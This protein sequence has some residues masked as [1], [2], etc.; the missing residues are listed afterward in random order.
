MAAEVKADI[1]SLGKEIE[2]LRKH[3]GDLAGDAKLSADVRAATSSISKK[4][5][6]LSTV[7]T[8]KASLGLP[9]S[10]SGSPAKTWPPRGGLAQVANSLALLENAKLQVPELNKA[11]NLAIKPA[12]EQAL[13]KALA[14]KAAYPDGQ[15]VVG[16][17]EVSSSFGIRGNPFGGA[18]YEVH[19]GIDFIGEQGDIIAATGN[20]VVTQAGFNGG[21]GISVTI[22]HGYGYE[23]LYAHMSEKRVSSGDEV[24]RGQIIGYIGSTGRSSGP[25]LHYGIYKDNVA[26]DPAE[27]MASPERQMA[28]GPR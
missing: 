17:A 11:V 14:V 24:K 9:I 23:T 7:T 28:V 12:L 8:R 4:R 20:G 10:G 19:E 18:S 15:P 13:D 3:A 22:D 5:S 2:S 26:I 6:G 16:L 27:I 21:Y 1:D 25:H